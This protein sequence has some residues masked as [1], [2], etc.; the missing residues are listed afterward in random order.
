M[1]KKKRNMKRNAS[2]ARRAPRFPRERPVVRSVVRPRQQDKTGEGVFAGTKSGFGFVALDGEETEDIFIPAGRCGGALDGDRVT[3]R[4]HHYESHG[5]TRSEGEVTHILEAV[6]K[7]VIGTLCALETRHGKKRMVS[8]YVEPDD[9]KIAL[10]VFLPDCGDAERGDKVEAALPPRRAGAETVIGTYLRTFGPAQSREANYAAILSECEV[11]VPFSREELEEAETV[12][13][14][15]LSDEGRTRRTDEI[16]FTI[17]GAGAKDLDDAVSLKRAK[18]GN[19]LL[20]VHIADVSTYVRPRT[21]LDAAAMRRGTSVYFTDQV[22]PMLPPALSNGSCSLN[23]GEDKYALSCLME[24]TPDGGFV[25]TNIERSLIRSRVRGVYSEVNDLFETGESSAFYPKYKAVYPTLCEMHDLYLVLAKKS[26]ARGALDLE[27]TE[28]EIL[29]DE[30][31]EPREIVPRV[32]GDAEKMIEQFMLAAN[33]A[34]ATLLFE[35]NLPCVYRIHESPS[36]EKLADFLTFAHNLNLNVAPLA[37][38]NPDARAFARLLDEAKE[39]GIGE[40]VSYTLLRTMMKARYS[41]H[42]TP[43]FGLGIEKYCHFTSPIRRLSD[44]ATHRAIE[45]VLIDGEAPQK[46]AS[47][48]RRAALA[49]SETELRA[50]NAERRIEA[51]YKTIYLSHHIGEIYPAIVTSV[52]RFGVFAALENTCE[53]LIPL[54]DLPGAWHFDEGNLMLASAAGETIRL[55]DRITVSVEEADIAKCKVRFAPVS[56]PSDSTPAPMGKN[57][58]ELR[59]PRPEKRP[60]EDL[61]RGGA[62]RTR[63][64]SRRGN[65]STPRADSRSRKKGKRK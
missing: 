65:K 3:V 33:E 43:H 25:K 60:T 1:T 37:N 15:P 9:P 30:G 19:W 13:K 39:K 14:M 24:L 26:R 63:S 40:A 20:G 54:T 62:P 32:R 35:K 47:Y 64:S 23:A 57:A 55:G 28:A 17:D 31:G 51:L 27:Q 18:N 21:A 11:P 45:A 2:P 52:T 8:Y 12:S 50:L 22:V 56:L 7:T 5:E 49:A 58:A 42:C 29:L 53:G 41:E 46:Y 44:L 4:Y 61:S 48:V 38:G 6:R 34:V 59:E 16:I 36:K 10:T